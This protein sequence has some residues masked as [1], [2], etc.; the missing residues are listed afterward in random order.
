VHLSGPGTLLATSEY[1]SSVWLNAD[2]VMTEGGLKLK[3]I[4]I[5]KR[6]RETQQHKLWVANTHTGITVQD[7]TIDGSAAAGIFVN[8]ASNF[9]LNRVIVMNTMADGIHMT[10]AS[11][12]GIVRDAVVRGTGDDGIAVVSYLSNPQAVHD[13]QIINPKVYSTTWARGLSVVGGYNISYSNI[14]V[15]ASNA[16]AVYIVQTSAKEGV[17]ASWDTHN[18]NNVKVIGG[19]LVNSN[20]NGSVNNG[21]VVVAA[22]GPAGRTVS[23]VTMSGLLIKNT[24]PDAARNVGV[25][26]Y[27]GGTVS[28]I[29]FKGIKTVGGP[30][31]YFDTNATGGYSATGWIVDGLG[32]PSRTVK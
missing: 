26:T 14:Y 28:K 15:E 13:I 21:A 5:T 24:R 27:N 3:A 32:V 25:F 8:G 18:V 17:E 30:K 12:D 6:W 10:N 16:S 4:N 1:R 23:N 2:N 20:T 29:L 19:S 9:T 7:T 22:A 11:H 31:K